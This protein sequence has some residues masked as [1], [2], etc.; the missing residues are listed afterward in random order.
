MEKDELYD[1]CV[2]LLEE[3]QERLE[4]DKKAIESKCS[5]LVERISSLNKEITDI[6]KRS[7]SAIDQR[8]FLLLKIGEA[9]NESMSKKTNNK[10][11]SDIKNNILL[12]GLMI[13][14][15]KTPINYDDLS[16]E[17]NVV[18]EKYLYGHG[19]DE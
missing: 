17:L 3:K 5:I 4:K 16:Y 8:N 7:K 2:T 15:A 11:V 13:E 6:K 1:K 9:L 12:S 14:T 10:C 19:E 18:I